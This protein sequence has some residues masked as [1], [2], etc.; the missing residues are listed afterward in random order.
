MNKMRVCRAVSGFFYWI[1]PCDFMVVL[2]TKRAPTQF[3]AETLAEIHLMT[4]DRC[5]P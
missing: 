5:E 3:E 4:C 1:A 2:N